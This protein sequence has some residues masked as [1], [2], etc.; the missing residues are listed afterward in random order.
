M[1]KKDIINHVKKVILGEDIASGLAKTKKVQKTEKQFNDDY[2]KDTN[3]KFKNYGK[4]N[5]YTSDE[6]KVVDDK[7]QEK[8]YGG[9]GMEGLTYDNEGTEVEKSFKKRNNELN[10]S[11]KNYYL[12]KDEVND[13]YTKLTSKGDE[14]KKERKKHSN[15]PPVRTVSTESTIKRLTYKTE[16]LNE[17]V[18]FKLIPENFKEDNKVFEMTDGNKL[19]KI[20]WEGNN[21]NGNPIVL[22]Y[23]DTKKI[24]EELDKMHHLFEYNSR[25]NF[26]KSNLMTEDKELHDF[27]ENKKKTLVEQTTTNPTTTTT[28]SPTSNLP[29]GTCY[30]FRDI[31]LSL[32]QNGSKYS[33]NLTDTKTNKVF[34]N[35]VIYDGNKWIFD[36]NL[37]KGTNPFIPFSDGKSFVDY[38]I[39]LI[40]NAVKGEASKNLSTFLKTYNP[41]DLNP[42][43]KTTFVN[44]L[45]YWGELG[46]GAVSVATKKINEMT[47]C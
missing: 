5:D 39:A 13:V 20:R 25:N 43:Q 24:N 38:S 16:F 26:G 10:K 7:E 18:I 17:S 31:N 2:Y 33:V 19:L 41:I 22:L 14:Y 12:K 37:Q 27:F 9:S 29:K 21:H 15:T 8:T 42:K 4:I 1:K 11:S 3:K 34:N 45:S 40:V 28:V 6:P 32:Q 36:P 46:L 35:I 44:Q 23:K 47:P 30:N